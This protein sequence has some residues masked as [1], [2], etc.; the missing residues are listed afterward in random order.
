[1]EVHSQLGPGL[2]ESGYEACL[3]QELALRGIQA[4]RQLVLPILYK[5]IQVDNGYRIDVL[6]EQ[7]LLLELKAVDKITSVHKAQ[8]MT[9]LKLSNLWLGLLINFNEVHLKD[10]I[11]RVVNGELP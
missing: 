9:Y 10:G 2:L 7:C 4:E 5:G 3:C 8:T 6:V 1:M 11:T